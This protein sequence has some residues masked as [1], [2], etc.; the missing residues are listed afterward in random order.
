MARKA[1]LCWAAA[2]A[3]RVGLG[4]LAGLIASSAVAQSDPV[5]G[6]ATPPRVE[7]QP[8][9]QPGPGGAGL[10]PPKMTGMPATLWLG[11]DPERLRSLIK[12]ARPVVP[13]LRDLLHTLML[14]EA[15]PPAQGAQGVAHLAAR[16]DWL[17]RLGAVE[18][19]LALLNIAGFDD[20]QLFQRWA[21]LNLLLGRTEAPC[22]AILVRPA[23]SDDIALRVFCTARAK[24]WQRA[25]LLLATASALGEVTDRKADLLE[26][27]LDDEI[28]AERPPLLPPVRP[29]PLEFRL[30]EAIGEA[31]PTAPLPL[32]FS[33][34][35][36]SGDNGWRAQIEA[37]ERLARVGAVPANRLL[38]LYT[39][40]RAAA[41]GGVWDRVA[42]LQDFE[43]SLDRGASGAISVALTKVWPQMAS[44]GLLEPFA[45]LFAQRLAEVPLSGRAVRMSARAG[46]LSQSYEQLSASLGDEGAQTA[47]LTQIARGLAPTEPL[48]AD[49]PHAAA[50]AASFSGAP[51][52]PVLAE[53]LQQGRLGEVILRSVALFASG[54]EGNSADLTD[55]LAVLR[56]VG[57]EDVARR[58]ALQIML[59]DAE[60]ARR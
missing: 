13:A 36:L 8:L 25:E 19:A 58:A 21:D 59:L 5:A 40:R 1:R 53:Q 55:A 51:V 32:S 44:A 45:S 41:S 27:F 22:N 31:L 57:L 39:L 16:I 48:N 15:D 6:T 17:I 54:A 3:R 2:S 30:F 14:A 4:L 46:F 52:P 42:A 38:G 18:E 60:R 37:A 9:G 33:V 34:L 26:R 28:N 47:F 12:A 56:A 50:V 43:K 20:P 29:T 11:S 7:A 10:L 24:D 49:L 35:D 23:L